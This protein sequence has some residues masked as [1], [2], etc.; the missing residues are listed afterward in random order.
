MTIVT[1]NSL[2]LSNVNDGTIT[3]YA[4]AYSAD[5]TDGFSTVYPALN[6]LSNSLFNA[7]IKTAPDSNSAFYGLQSNVVGSEYLPSTSNRDL[8]INSLYVAGLELPIGVYTSSITIAN[9]SET[10]A[11]VNLLLIKGTADTDIRPVVNGNS[12]P[13]WFTSFGNPAVTINIPANSNARYTFTFTAKS[14]H[15]TDQSQFIIFRETTAVPVTRYSKPKLEQGSTATPYMPSSSEVTTA[16]WPSYIGQYTDFTQADSTNPSNYTWSLIRGNDGKDG[17]NGKDGIA[18]KDGVGIKTT[19]IT[20][21]ISTS[22]TI[23]PTTGWTSSVPGLVKGQYLWTKTVWTYTDNSSETGYSVTYISKDG[24]NGNDGIAG[25][26]G[27]GILTTTITY[28]GSTSGTTAPTSGWTSTVPTVEAGSYLWTKTVWA[29]TDNTSETGYSVAKMGNTGPTGPAGAPGT[30]GAPGKIVSDTEPTTRFKGLTWKYSGT[31][32]LTASDGTVIKP[33]IEYY[34]NGTKW[35]INLIEANQLNV[36]ELAAISAYLGHVYAAIVEDK[37]SDGSGFLL[38]SE[39]QL[40]RV[41]K[42]ANTYN[43]IFSEGLTT[44]AK[45]S[46]L[47][48]IG[49]IIPGAN[50]ISA[51]LAGN[52][53]QFGQYSTAVDSDGVPVGGVSVGEGS[54]SFGQTTSGSYGFTLTG[55]LTVAGNIKSLKDTDW[56]DIPPASGWGGTMRYMIAEGKFYLRLT[57]VTNPAVSATTAR[58]MCTIPTTAVPLGGIRGIPIMSYGQPIAELVINANG[59]IQ[60]YSHD[61]VGTGQSLHVFVQ[62]IPLT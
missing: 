17:A 1:K 10:V 41:N 6:L 57:N 24:N 58:T 4:Y 33:N 54:I 21:A 53:I 7:P 59:T 15:N 60:F 14:T 18:G 43:Q 23:A 29:Y 49:N 61:A 22:G 34:Y 26:D 9:N 45:I 19:V 40:L 31:A 2:T 11:I 35:L 37:Q 5:G 25:K 16:D 32:D 8:T 62:G 55:D 42:T 36:N 27:V 46:D 12:V 13:W 44:F 38:N 48:G 51:I 52:F 30:N 3:H 20:Y 56:I 39:K 50:Y 47:P 28:A